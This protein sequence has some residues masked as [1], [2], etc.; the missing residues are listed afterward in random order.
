M[1]QYIGSN[2]L[3][4]YLHPDPTDPF[5][6]LKT[7]P[8]EPSSPSNPNLIDI[9]AFNSFCQ[10]LV[11]TS[12]SSSNTSSHRP[13]VNSSDLYIQMPPVSQIDYSNHSN[14]MNIIP[15]SLPEENNYKTDISTSISSPNV[16][17]IVQQNSSFD[18]CLSNDLPKIISNKQQQQL[19]IND[20][21][22]ISNYQLSSK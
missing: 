8:I 18:Q 17:H 22:I 10:Q 19:P 5:L 13:L 12:P 6:E 4:T 15:S 2:N 21:D 14:E 16:K 3:A 11:E 9:C 20:D 1:D 7:E